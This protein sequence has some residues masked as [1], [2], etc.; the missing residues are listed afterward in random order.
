VSLY[1]RIFE[2]PALREAPP[3]LVDVGA[4]YNLH[5]AWRRLAPYAIGVGFEPDR[6]G[7]TAMRASAKRFKHWISCDR[8][9]VPGMEDSSPFYLT[10]SSYCSSTLQPDIAALSDWTFAELF[11]VKETQALPATQLAVVLKSHGLVHLDWLK[12]DTQGTDLR[13][14]LSLP[15]D[16][17]RRVLTVEFEPGLIDAYHGEDKLL[18][19]LAAMEHE[20]FW[21]AQMEMQGVPRGRRANLRK[22]LGPAWTKA[23]LNFGPVAPGWA[24]LSYLHRMTGEDMQ[25]VREYLLAWV[26][27]TELNQPAFA[28]E[29]AESG[30]ERFNDSIFSE[31]AAASVRGMRWAVIQAWPNWPSK[32]W[33][34]FMG[35]PA[36]GER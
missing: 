20:P 19:V 15:P 31:L 17:R 36:S 14:F 7:V 8:I 21:L 27:A 4:S 26:F 29:L 3:V 10:K 5:P 28:L 16:I 25:G 11:E 23:Y 18:T 34:K 9:V 2:H 13:I 12:C 30:M 22:R 6:R 24:N 32:L 1:E 33:H 35:R